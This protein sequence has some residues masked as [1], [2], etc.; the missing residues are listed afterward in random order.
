MV[1]PSDSKI[2]DNFNKPENV[3]DTGYVRIDG[4]L[5]LITRSELE[6]LMENNKQK[7]K[8][9]Y[10][11]K[12]FNTDYLFALQSLLNGVFTAEGS[13][14]GQFSSLTSHRFTPKFSIGQN[15]SIESI[16]LFSLMWAILD[17]KL[18]WEISKTNK[19]NY[20][21]QLRTTNIKYMISTLFPYFSFTYGEKFT[22]MAKLLRLAKLVQSDTVSAKFETICLVYSL[23][24][25]GRNRLVSLREKLL[26]C[27][28]ETSI[29]LTQKSLSAELDSKNYPENTAYINICFIMGF[30]L[31]DGCLYIRIRDKQ[32]GLTFVP[33]FEIK[34]KNIPSSL[35]LMKLICEFF[36]K[37][38]IEASLRTDKHYVLGIIEGID[39]VCSK[40]LPLLEVHQELF[41]WKRRQLKMTN[42]FG[43]LILLDNRNL[44]SVKYLLIKTIYSID[45]NRNYSFEHWIKRI[46]EIFKKKSTLNVSGEFYIS[47]VKDKQ[48]KTIQ[49]GWSVF[50][51][52]FLAVSPRTKYFYFS[53]F[54]GKDL[55]LSAAIAYRNSVIE[56]WLQ[57]QG[58]IID[59]VKVEDDVD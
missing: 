39:N 25:G 47:P 21:I 3:E 22:A 56:N 48:V 16:E 41:F 15:A 2:S 10:L 55:A 51:P 18:V 1:K 27:I 32:T 36:H 28:D 4:F 45:N 40:L 34:Q 11:K 9:N 38:G 35:H 52:E 46:D 54:A 26:S 7:A 37:K 44:L 19:L 59:P 57:D 17:C 20:H 8:E 6:D 42:Q 49:T 12:R 5:V 24:P 43:K 13:W 30:F 58:Y 29:N 31:G 50:L 23:S 14:S 53:N 33:K